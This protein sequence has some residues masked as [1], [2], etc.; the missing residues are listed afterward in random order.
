MAV[1]GN[2]VAVSVGGTVV[3]VGTSVA[4]GL[5]SVGT[6]VAV[7]PSTIGVLV[8]VSSS[9]WMDRFDVHS[10]SSWLKCSEM[11]PWCASTST[12]SRIGAAIPAVTSIRQ[13]SA[14]AVPSGSSS[15]ES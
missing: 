6:S 10:V 8:G 5:I 2:A 11:F 9:K 7:G 1:I 12:S 3:S 13:T 15:R 4:A 14:G